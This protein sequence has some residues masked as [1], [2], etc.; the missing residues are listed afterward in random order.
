[1]NNEKLFKLRKI[2]KKNKVDGYL[3]PHNDEYFNESIPE[4]NKRL[5]WLTSFDGSAG[6]ALILQEKAYLFVDGRYTIQAKKQV[7]NKL[8]DVIHSKD[9]NIYQLL[10]SLTSKLTIGFDPKIHSIINIKNLKKNITNS[11]I[12]FKEIKNNLIDLVWDKKP[13]LIFN[14]IKIH[15]LKFTGQPSHEKISHVNEL[16]KK[17]LADSIIITDCESIAWL[18]NIRGSDLDF[19]PIPLSILILNNNNEII[20]FT[21][22]NINTSIK[23]HFGNKIKVEKLCKVENYL[24][25]LGQNKLKVIIDER[26]CSFWAYKILESHGAEILFKNDP[27]LI[28]KACKNKTELNGIRNAHIRDGISLVKTLYWIKESIQKK[29]L[30]EIAVSDKLFEFRSNNENFT[31]LSFPTIAGTGANGAIVH[32]RPSKENSREINEGDLLLMDS[33]GQYFDGTT[34]VTRTIVIGE[35]TK[36]KKI[37]FTKVL[38]GHIAIASAVFPYDT[39]GHQLDILAR[40]FLWKSG[41]D[42]EHGTGHGVGTFLNVHEGPQNI[43][44]YENNIK[45]EEGM[46]ISNEPGYYKEGEYGI[47]IENLVAVRRENNFS[48]EKKFLKFETLTL[49][50]IDLN[51][52]EIGLLDKNE[53]EWIN[54]YHEK[55]FS[56]LS[57]SLS[58]E[59]KEWLRLETKKINI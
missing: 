49:A 14:D 51:L 40:Q 41:L 17:Y 38:K 2:I 46:I 45:L 33:G 57:N 8:F 19:T 5:E 39:T 37:M 30:N 55:V 58:T 24:I 32:Y 31:G 10:N 29:L 34:D 13:V 54:S 42:Y 12:S 56:Q 52:I 36:E 59:I 9:R 23:K 27:C 18:L 20:F 22:S 4:A 1:M 16:I 6:L 35:P 44:K 53:I 7:D 25:R 21:N 28:L 48:S 47:R 50:P 43:S 15:E 3:V 11:S 26:T